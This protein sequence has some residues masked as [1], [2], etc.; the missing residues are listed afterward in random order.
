MKRRRKFGIL[1]IIIFALTAIIIVLY[2]AARPPRYVV[3][4]NRTVGLYRTHHLSLPEG[5]LVELEQNQ[6]LRFLEHRVRRRDRFWQG[7][8]KVEYNGETGWI[9]YR[10]LSPESRAEI[11]RAARF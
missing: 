5:P 11:E 8:V 9:D 1:G 3:T 6:K 7:P 4:D 10:Y 2:L